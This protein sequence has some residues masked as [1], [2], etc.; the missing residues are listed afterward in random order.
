MAFLRKISPFVMVV[1]RHYGMCFLAC[2][3]S[4]FEL[5]IPLPVS[6]DD[7]VWSPAPR[8]GFSM[9]VIKRGYCPTGEYVEWYSQRWWGRPW[10]ARLSYTVDGQTLIFGKI[11]VV[12]GLKGTGLG[13]LLYKHMN[14]D[15]ITAVTSEWREDNLEAFNRAYRNCD[16]TPGGLLAAGQQTPDAKM[17]RKMGFELSSIDLENGIPIVEYRPI[18]A[19][20]SGN[21][22]DGPGAL[23]ARSGLSSGRLFRRADVLGGLVGG[24]ELA[25]AAAR[26]EGGDHL[27]SQL[28]VALPTASLAARSS[29]AR[30]IIGAGAKWA[31]PA[32]WAMNG[33]WELG[34]LVSDEDGGHR[35]RQEKV[36]SQLPYDPSGNLTF[37]GYMQSVGNSMGDPVGFVRG[38]CELGYYGAIFA[39]ENG[40]GSEI[41]AT[42]GVIERERHRLRDGTCAVPFSGLGKFP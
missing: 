27:K 25:G 31:E 40:R 26:G 38:L 33:A 39:A 13:S 9:G 1:R 21:G 15:G 35:Y 8:L 18:P 24:L 12:Q 3:L 10:G 20:S 41:G 37:G 6:A 23:D 19:A 36:I 29:T 42:G 32:A 14:L 17:W 4:F 5:I 30:W 28:A 7:P 2:I 16:E 22:C 34:H 11:E